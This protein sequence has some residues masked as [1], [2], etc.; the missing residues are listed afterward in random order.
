[1]IEV[2]ILCSMAGAVLTASME[3][4]AYSRHKNLNHYALGALRL[5]VAVILIISVEGPQIAEP[6]LIPDLILMMGAFAPTHRLSLNLIRIHAYQTPIQWHHLG[7]QSIYDRAWTWITAQVGITNG[8]IR[9]LLL[10]ALELLVAGA[11]YQQLQP[12]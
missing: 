7:T 10:C 4:K 9:F 3:A 1:M 11:V 6:R 8:E 12:A 5:M 2:L